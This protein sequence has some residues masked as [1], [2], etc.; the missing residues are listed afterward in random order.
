MNKNKP[1]FVDKIASF[2]GSW[3][4]VGTQTC[5]IFFW[6][7]GNS[8]GF[9]SFDSYPFVFLNL[10]LSFQAAFTAPI[11][12]MSQNRDAIQDRAN[13]E[14]DYQVDMK[15]QKQIEIILEKLDYLTKRS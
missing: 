6:I 10:A 2:I 7:L 3:K 4:F 13:N 14:S 12:M 11:I 5:I 15:A 1:S 9:F 8:T